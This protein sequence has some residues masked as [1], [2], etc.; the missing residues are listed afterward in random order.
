MIGKNI[1]IK[2]CDHYGGT[3]FSCSGGFSESWDMPKAGGYHAKWRV[4]ENE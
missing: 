1:K 3:G 2:Q 4:K